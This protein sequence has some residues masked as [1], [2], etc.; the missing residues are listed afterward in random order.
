[1]TCL[2]RSDMLLTGSL[3]RNPVLF[4]IPAQTGIKTGIFCCIVFG[5]QKFPSTYQD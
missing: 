1:M 4:V 2:V 3:V 5:K